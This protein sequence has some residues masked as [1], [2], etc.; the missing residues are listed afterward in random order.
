[1]AEAALF[2]AYFVVSV[3]VMAVRGLGEIRQREMVGDGVR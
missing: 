2:S 3:G 1:M